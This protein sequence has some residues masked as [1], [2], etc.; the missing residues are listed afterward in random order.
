MYPYYR[1]LSYRANIRSQG[2]NEVI[3]SHAFPASPGLTDSTIYGTFAGSFHHSTLKDAKTLIERINRYPEYSISFTGIS[4]HLY[5]AS[6]T[7]CELL[8]T[9]PKS[10]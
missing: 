8:E 7:L 6:T 4:L 1:Q 2:P 10:A 5:K 9:Y 3:L